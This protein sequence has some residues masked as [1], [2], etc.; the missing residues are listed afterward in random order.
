MKI[1]GWMIQMKIREIYLKQL[2]TAWI[3]FLGWSAI[4]F[5]VTD[6]LNQFD[7]F[8]IFTL[9][10]LAVLSFF[11]GRARG[12]QLGKLMGSLDMFKDLYS[13]GFIQNLNEKDEEKLDEIMGFEQDGKI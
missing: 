1:Y 5:M 4:L 10:N 8:I 11:I 13:H 3:V 12:E 7:Q 6:M 2:K 9:Q